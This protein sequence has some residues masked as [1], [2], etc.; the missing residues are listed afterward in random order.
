MLPNYVDEEYGVTWRENEK[1]KIPLSSFRFFLLEIFF[2]F[3][4]HYI[5]QGRT[6][7]KKKLN[8]MSFYD[9][10]ELK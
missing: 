6:V 1:Q 3:S 2:F 9:C 7:L 5:T 4:V 10:F 8:F